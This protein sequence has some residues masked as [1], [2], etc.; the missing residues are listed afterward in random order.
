MLPT[1]MQEEIVPETGNALDAGETMEEQTTESQTSTVAAPSEQE[2]PATS[3]A[4][5]EVGSGEPPTTPLSASRPGSSPTHTRTAT[6]PIVPVIPITPKV[7]VPTARKPS[8]VLSPPENE[9]EGES[10]AGAVATPPKS[11]RTRSSDTLVASPQQSTPAASRSEPETA[12]STATASKPAAPKSWAD[13]VRT[14]AA[15]NDAASPAVNGA[16]TIDVNVSNAGS[17]AD[18]IR[19]FSVDSAAKIS[20]LKPRGL[21][22]SGNMCYMNSVCFP[23]H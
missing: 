12:E 7:A 4:P 9:K 20:F 16:A 6:R 10:E 13:L 19:A 22:N 11:D 21:V 3:Q 8:V 2:T 23:Y 15:K 1:R 5:S 17:L 14:K 18:A